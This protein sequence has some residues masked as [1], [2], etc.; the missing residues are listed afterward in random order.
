MIEATR[1]LTFFSLICL[2][3][4][5]LS[6]SIW[7]WAPDLFIAFILF[8]TTLKSKLPSTYLF[9]LY[10]FSIDLFFSDQSLPYTITFFLIGAYLSFSNIKW[11]QRSLLEQLLMIV[12]TSIFLNILL[13]FINDYSLN[14]EARIIL[15]PLMNALIWAAIFMTQRHKWLKNF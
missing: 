14:I 8:L 12:I 4:I 9:I 6:T 7:V 13:N 10:G 11:I 1:I 3:Y 15:N 2:N 5:F